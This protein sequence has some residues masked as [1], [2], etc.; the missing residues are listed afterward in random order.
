MQA[1]RVIATAALA[2]G[3]AAS[4]GVATAGA[5]LATDDVPICQR[6]NVPMDQ[7]FH[8]DFNEDEFFHMPYGSA[9]NWKK[10]IGD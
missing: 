1:K 4:G 9:T 7:G 6:C 2:L 8:T 5:A 3:I 10:E